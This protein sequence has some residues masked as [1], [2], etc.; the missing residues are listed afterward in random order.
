M[1]EKT[2]RDSLLQSGIVS[3]TLMVPV[4]TGFALQEKEWRKGRRRG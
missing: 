3:A 2:R 4:V 1:Q